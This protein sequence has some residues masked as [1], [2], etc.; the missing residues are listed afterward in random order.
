[1]A[2]EV[3]LLG[4]GKAGKG[5]HEPLVRSV[6]G[7]N[8]RTIARRDEVAKVIDDP[9]IQLVVVATPNT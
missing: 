5:F 1:M 7:L 4:Y 9:A 6:E 2:I 3:G 8:L